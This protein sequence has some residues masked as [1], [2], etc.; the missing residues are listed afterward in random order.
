MN[1]PNTTTTGTPVQAPV[2][3]HRIAGVGSFPP[4]L[5]KL[6][7]PAAKAVKNLADPLGPGSLPKLS[8]W[9]AV[10]Q[11]ANAEKDR[12]ILITATE[13][14][15]SWLTKD[16]T[17]RMTSAPP[18]DGG[19][20]GGTESSDLSKAI[21]YDRFFRVVR[22][23]E[24]PKEQQVLALTAALAVVMNDTAIVEG[25]ETGICPNE[26]AM[27]NGAWD[28]GIEVIAETLG[29]GQDARP[30]IP[31]TVANGK[32][33]ETMP[34]RWFR[35]VGRILCRIARRLKPDT[36]TELSAE[37][38]NWLTFDQ[39]AAEKWRRGHHVFFVL[40]TLVIISLTRLRRALERKDWIKAER[41][42]GQG[43]AFMNGA[44]V[45]IARLLRRCCR[46]RHWPLAILRATCSNVA[47]S[48]VQ[49]GLQDF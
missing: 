42:F 49:K 22:V 7:L 34:R 20:A 17:V 6:P 48:S 9:L 5:P 10:F 30:V 4:L 38:L 21:I 35:T 3:S 12:S 45:A 27:L 11:E 14:F 41:Y 1:T 31:P 28:F 8:D 44:A 24:D 36:F 23:P 25:G 15:V 39:L 29:D 40:I 46:S 16:P 32:K 18:E 19:T 37:L 47:W 13:D 26:F 43:T 33:A 2:R